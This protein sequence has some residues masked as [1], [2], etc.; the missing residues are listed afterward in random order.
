MHRVDTLADRP[1]GSRPER[2][3]PFTRVVPLDQI[4]AETLRVGVGT[5]TVERE[6]QSLIHYCG[7]EF[8]VLLKA[9][10]E[11]LRKATSPQIAESILRVREGR[12]TIEPGYDGEYGK[13][14]FS[15]SE[16]AAAAGEQQMTL[17]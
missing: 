6:Y 15:E 3:I 5:Q 4:I 2:A 10:E 12:V 13:V 8:S 16:P 1:E 9:S 17:F 11:E 7:T 14:H